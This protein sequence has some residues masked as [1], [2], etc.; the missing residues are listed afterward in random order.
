M[1]AILRRRDLIYI[2]QQSYA[3]MP[4]AMPCDRY[5]APGS[6]GGSGAQ[7]FACRASVLSEHGQR[8]M[9]SILGTFSL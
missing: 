2:K 6:S 8:R 1:Y 4:I 5:S 9:A 3:A 7:L